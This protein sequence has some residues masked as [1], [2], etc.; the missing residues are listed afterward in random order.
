MPEFI[1]IDA[2]EDRQ[3][4]MRAHAG[5]DH[6]RGPCEHRAL[7]QENLWHASRNRRSKYRS[8]ISGI[9]NI[10]QQQAA[11]NT[12]WH[13]TRQGRADDRRD[14]G[15]AHELRHSLEKR[16]RENQTRFRRYVFEE[17]ADFRPG[18]RALARE[19]HLGDTAAVLIRPHQTLP[20][21]DRAA[22][23]AALPRRAGKPDQGLDLR[24][25]SRADGFHS[26]AQVRNP[27]K[28]SMR[29]GV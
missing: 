18:E 13:R 1:D 7:R 29:S 6:L 8:Q 12:L 5:S 4:E 26:M 2:F 28:M 15:R 21:Q 10:F 20:F 17:A 14:S 25:V 3:G 22:G 24:V 27:A 11:R 23:P 19:Y 9:L 16:V